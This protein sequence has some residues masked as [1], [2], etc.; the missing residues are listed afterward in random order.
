MDVTFS[1]ADR[2][3]AVKLAM[4][5]MAIP[6]LSGQ[7]GAVIDDITGRLRQ[8]GLPA[9]A[10]QRDAAHRKSPIGGEEGNLIVKLPGTVRRPRRLFCAHL[11]TVSICAGSRPVLRRDRIVPAGRDSGLGGDDRA[12]CAVILNALLTILRDR[13]PH[14]PLTFLWTVQEEAGLQG[15]RL[16]AVSKLGRPAMGFNY[17]GS[18][19]LTVGATGA[20]RMAF[21]LHGIPSHAGVRPAEGVSAITIA[22]LAVSDLHR[23]GWLGAVRKGGRKGTGNVGVVRAG[24]STNVVTPLAEVRAEVRSHDPAFRREMLRA[25]RDAFRRAAKAVRNSRG[26]CGK[27]EM[28]HRLDYESF[29]LCD[30]E[31]AVTAAMEAARA[32]GPCHERKI[33]D[34][35]VDANWLC[36]HGI[37][38]VTLGAGNRNPHT[39]DEFVDVGAF[40]QGCEVAL[41]LG[42][43]VT[44]APRWA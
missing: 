38:T 41:R 26:R 14:P 19:G 21:A 2:R 23:N 34:G 44:P 20:Y 40:G 33:G 29:R 32:V 16:V 13:L 22:S 3:G 11:D 8:A 25:Y 28:E 37:P 12:G 15:S 4:D 30:D 17:D 5:L 43:D 1:D 42:T 10:I 18:D 24:E 39:V 6:G 27:V 36:L 35:G 7:E 9:G 31:P